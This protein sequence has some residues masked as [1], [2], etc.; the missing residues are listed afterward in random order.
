ELSNKEGSDADNKPLFYDP[1]RYQGIQFNE[2]TRQQ[3]AEINAAKEKSDHATLRL[4]RLVLADVLPAVLPYH[5]S[6]LAVSDRAA[7]KLASVAFGFFLLGRIT[8]AWLLKRWSAHR[9][10]GLYALINVGVCAL[11]INQLGWISVACV[12]ASYFFMS[13]MFPTIFALG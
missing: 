9:T 8:G 10:L 7:A 5:D 2:K 3:A 11:I 12:F 4:N 1:Q 6:I 13:I